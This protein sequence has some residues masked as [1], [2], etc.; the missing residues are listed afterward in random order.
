[1][2]ASARGK[3]HSH[4]L[5]CDISWT[6]LLNSILLSALASCLKD[7]SLSQEIMS[8]RMKA[9]LALGKEV[10]KNIPAPS[11]DREYNIA[12]SS[13]FSFCAGIG[14]EALPWASDILQ[15]SA[16]CPFQ[17]NVM[18]YTPML[19]LY[20][21]CGY[22]TKV[23]ELLTQMVSENQMPNEVTLGDLINAAASSFDFKRADQLWDK[24]VKQH[25]II[26]NVIC[27]VGK[28]KVHILAGRP[29][30]AIQILDRMRVEGV[31]ANDTNAAVVYLQALLLTCHSDPSKPRLKQLST[32]L[33]EAERTVAGR[34]TT[35]GKQMQG[36][37]FTMTKLGRN[38]VKSPRSV[39]FADLLVYGNAKHGMMK[40]WPNYQA[41][42]QYLSKMDQ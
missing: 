28:A 25:R 35:A 38:L 4:K 11:N 10:W 8:K 3:P 34:M 31:G 16:S 41:G 20:E 23:D 2:E 21:R 37:W 33:A 1:M 18:A 36:Q 7:R 14:R 6:F 12:L 9:G 22:Y 30:S 5:N 24:L 15:W 17:A 19:S 26:P 29:L 42:S 32:Y 13:A 40:T 27:Y 39:M